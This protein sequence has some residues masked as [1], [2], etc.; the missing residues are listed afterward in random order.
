MAS[1][2]KARLEEEE[3]E[4]RKL[5]GDLKGHVKGLGECHCAL[6]AVVGVSK[7]SESE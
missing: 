3:V 6:H 1:M 2:E 4:G 5:I 7:Q